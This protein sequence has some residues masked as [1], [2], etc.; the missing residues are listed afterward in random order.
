M[1]SIICASASDS[2]WKSLAKMLIGGAIIEE[3]TGDMKVKEDTT[4][5]AAHFLPSDQFFEFSGSSGPAQVTC[6]V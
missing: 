1:E 5:V 6:V 2:T 3:H 4:K